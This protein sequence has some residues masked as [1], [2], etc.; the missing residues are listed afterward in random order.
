MSKYINK[1]D[2]LMSA[3][4]DINNDINKCYFLV[5]PHSAYYSCFLLMEHLC[6]KVFGVNNKN[7]IKNSVD[8]TQHGSHEIMITYVH[9]KMIQACTSIEDKHKAMDFASKIGQ[10]KKL[11]TKADYEEEDITYTH[12]CKAL[13]LAKEVRSIL[14]SFKYDSV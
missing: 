14:K 1:S 11:R 3:A 10:L 9:N 2:L 12:S 13:E 4:E 5:V 7:E 6:Y 8:S